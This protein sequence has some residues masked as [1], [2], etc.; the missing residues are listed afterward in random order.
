MS[1][2]LE[3]FKESFSKSCDLLLEGFKKG[4]FS[5]VL[6]TLRPIEPCSMSRPH[7]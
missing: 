6:P 1:T 2:V 7:P 4:E 5:E 3:S